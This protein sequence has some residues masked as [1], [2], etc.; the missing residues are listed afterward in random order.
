[1]HNKEVEGN[2]S[3]ELGNIKLEKSVL[4]ITKGTDSDENSLEHIQHEHDK[5]LELIDT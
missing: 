4:E 2:M 1:M 5:N 3:L